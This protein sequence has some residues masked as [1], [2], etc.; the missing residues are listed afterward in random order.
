MGFFDQV[1]DG[2]FMGLLVETVVTLIILGVTTIWAKIFF[3]PENKAE[4][5]WLN[6]VLL[7]LKLLALGSIVFL[8]V[9][10]YWV[11]DDIKG[12]LRGYIVNNAK[13]FFIKDKHLSTHRSQPPAKQ[14]NASVPVKK[15]IILG[16]ESSDKIEHTPNIKPPE[17]TQAAAEKAPETEPEQ[18]PKAKQTAETETKQEPASTSSQ[19]NTP[20]QATEIK[21][22]KISLT[23]GSVPQAPINTL[24]KR[25]RKNA[26][27]KVEQHLKANGLSEYKKLLVGKENCKGKGKGRRC[28]A[29]VTAIGFE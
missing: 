16:N 24:R 6:K 22:H 21:Q 28:T 7:C 10:F 9:V 29:K 1:Q 23:T 26:V 17:T 15:V 13:S 20:A 27:F 3:K 4:Q 11:W 18:T 8:S 25:L 2:V 19:K 12:D 5:N 14:E